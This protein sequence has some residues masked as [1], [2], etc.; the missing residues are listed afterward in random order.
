M[1]DDLDLGG[2]LDYDDFELP[3]PEGEGE[4][5]S[6]DPTEIA[7]TEELLAAVTARVEA[8]ASIGEI[9]LDPEPTLAHQPPPVV[10]TAA[11]VQAAA[12]AAPSVAPAAAPAPAAATGSSTLAVVGVAVLFFL[13]L[14]GATA[15]LLLGAG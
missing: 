4:D 15:A 5:V 9:E 13:I 2:P 14:A 8:N 12:A 10:P 3:L 1:Y 7:G 6:E 11:P